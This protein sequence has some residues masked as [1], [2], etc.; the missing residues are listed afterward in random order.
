MSYPNKYPYTNFHEMNLDW[1]LETMSD[2]KEA[3][4][5][6]ELAAGTS[7]EGAAASAAM[8]A[9]YSLQA[10]A[11]A[12]TAKEQADI[13]SIFD[14][15][16]DEYGFTYRKPFW[17]EQAYIDEMSEEFRAA[18]YHPERVYTNVFF[19]E[20]ATGL[21]FF[22]GIN[23][24]AQYRSKLIFKQIINIRDFMELSDDAWPRFPNK[25]LN[26]VTDY[27]PVSPGSDG[28][29]HDYL[30]GGWWMYNNRVTLPGDVPFCMNFEGRFMADTA[31][32]NPF[33]D[34]VVSAWPN[35]FVNPKN[36][37]KP[38][39]FCLTNYGVVQDQ[40]TPFTGESGG[41][42]TKGSVDNAMISL[43]GVMTFGT[44]P[45]I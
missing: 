2:A 16:A 24:D 19:N 5:A 34:S 40:S 28:V 39:R 4:E 10:Y 22:C 25:G 14:F 44:R 20:K 21:R 3:A 1:V 33:D 29:V 30:S 13:Y 17:E 38:I 23:P 6:A 26:L 42:Y 31:I 45:F 37:I 18:I 8:A 27:N 36:Y 12:K 41:G 32:D 7:K 43:Q 11:S 35:A 15:R 9:E